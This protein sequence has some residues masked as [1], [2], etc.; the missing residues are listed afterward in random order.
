MADGSSN[1]QGSGVIKIGRM[2]KRKLQFEGSDI[3]FELDVIRTGNRWAEIDGKF[4]HDPNGRITPEHLDAV[5]LQAI[6]FV[7]EIIVGSVGADRQAEVATLAQS[8]S[9]AD[10]FHFI[11][12]ITDEAEELKPFFTPKS[13]AARS[14]PE[15]T[16][17]TFS[18][19]K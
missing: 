10:A 16:E 6:A 3:V 13:A 18:T 1:G 17:V 9:G 2:G 8:I 14:S 5:T 7:Q 15:S 4:P 19:E 12:L 11:K